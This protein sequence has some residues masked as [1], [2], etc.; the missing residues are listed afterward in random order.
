MQKVSLRRSLVSGVAVASM[1]V[2]SAANAS[3]D[4]SGKISRVL[5]YSYGLVMVVGSWRGDY[6]AICSTDGTWGG[7]S[8]ETCLSWYAAA[9][10]AQAE[11]TTVDIYYANPTATTCTS[12]PTYGNSL[13]P[14]YVMLISS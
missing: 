7:I 12:L 5:M 13:P 14:G 4:C 10:K 3:L 8:T 11:N 2:V 1:L 6:T 9:L